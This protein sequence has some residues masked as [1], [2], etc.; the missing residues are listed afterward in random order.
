MQGKG[1]IAGVI[2]LTILLLQ[3]L[4]PAASAQSGSLTRGGTFTITVV[5]LPRTAYDIWPKGTSEM[6][7]EPGDQPPVIPPGQVDVTQDPAGGPYAIGSHPISGGGTI[8]DDVPPD[9][10]TTAATSYYAQVKTD[11]SG[12]GVVLFQTSSA[13]ATGQ[14]FHIVAQNPADLGE[15]VQ[16]FLG[17]IPTTAPTPVMPLPLPPFMETQTLPVTTTRVPVTVTH[18]PPPT[19]STTIPLMTPSPEK[20]ATETTPGQEIPISPAIALAAAGIGLFSV[21]RKNTGK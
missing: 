4:V 10:S 13:T 12:H 19:V 17:G 3:V 18:P 1:I 11:A 16:V 14:Q 8:R 5:G 2:F 6:T 21:G 20:T 7:G 9:S 15:E